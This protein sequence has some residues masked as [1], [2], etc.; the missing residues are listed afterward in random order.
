MR[1][2]EIAT[3]AVE[4]RSSPIEGL[5]LFAARAF[6]PG[7]RLH[8]VNV[9]REVTPEAP[10]RPE[11]GE[12]ADHCDYPDGRV[13][14]I[15]APDRHV[16]HSCDPSAYVSYE[17]DA[18]YLVARRAIPA[19][20]EITCDYSINV[21]GGSAWPCHCGAARCRGTVVGDC[22]QLPP[23]I[24]REYRPLLAQWFVRRH[25]A[26]LG[27]RLEIW[28]GGQTGVDR[29]ALDVALE[30]GL[31][32]GGWVPR[33]R[34]AEDGVV[35]SRYESLREADSPDYAER[36]RLNVRDA[37]ATLVLAMGAATGGTAFTLEEARR[38][39]RPVLEIDLS[40]ESTSE[41]AVR[42]RAWLESLVATRSFVRLNVAGPRASQAPGVYARA[43]QTLRDA[44]AAYAART[45]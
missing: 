26:Q 2:G 42:V 4:V 45:P 23:D 43:R 5:G 24:Q 16:N 30:L 12:R 41:A 22:F 19:G 3:P 37:D 31:P 6:H 29:S 32:L 8:H 36:T 11:L 44:L 13:V 7:E 1:D 18:C 34:L 15:G 27:P 40:A 33:G 28:S 10:L 20:A 35:P 21:T 38:V 39:G 14:L 25:A 17:E 9:V